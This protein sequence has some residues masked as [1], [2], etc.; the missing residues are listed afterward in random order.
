MIGDRTFV[1]SVRR[2]FDGMS[3]ALNI[4]NQQMKQIKAERNGFQ[5]AREKIVSEKV[6]SPTTAQ[7]NDYQEAISL[8]LSTTRVD[9]RL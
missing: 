3:V 8:G 2:F 4:N 6:L 5:V 7:L 1:C 9:R